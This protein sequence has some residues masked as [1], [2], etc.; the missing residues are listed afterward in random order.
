M[1]GGIPETMARQGADV[2]LVARSPGPIEY[3]AIT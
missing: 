3:E 1:G 2:H